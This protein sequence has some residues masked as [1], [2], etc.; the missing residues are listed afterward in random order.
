MRIPPGWVRWR[1]SFDASTAAMPRCIR[2]YVKLF[3]L[4]LSSKKTK[5]C[6]AGVCCS[7]SDTP[8]ARGPANFLC[9][10]SF[11]FRRTF[12][13]P[14][15]ELVECVKKFRWVTWSRIRVEIHNHTQPRNILFWT[16]KI[17]SRIKHQTITSCSSQPTLQRFGGHFVSR[18][19]ICWDPR[20]EPYNLL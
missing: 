15:P 2:G 1:R 7:G 8:R 18:M 4:K 9:W 6:K 10:T 3:S 14:C 5:D 11:T 17:I 13:C 16:E 20:Y 12:V 19:Q